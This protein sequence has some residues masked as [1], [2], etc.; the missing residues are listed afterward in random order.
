MASS[1]YQS[2][3]LPV[4]TERANWR[5]LLLVGALCV[6]LAFLVARFALHD[7]PAVGDQGSHRTGAL[8]TAK[9]HKPG[10]HGAHRRGSTSPAHTKLASG[11]HWSIRIPHSW[12]P[13]AAAGVRE[14]AG[15]RTPSKVA[16]AGGIVIVLHRKVDTPA[17]LLNYTYVESATLNTGVGGGSVRVLRTHV[18]ANHGEIEYLQ[19]DDNGQRIHNL[20]YVVQ[21]SNGFASLT[22]ATPTKT[23]KRDVKRV[24]SY[25]QTFKGR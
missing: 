6:A 24:E 17:D 12:R 10:D 15:W 23:F 11:P 1:D 9:H 18:Y 2:T 25:L 16:G 21:T 13:M 7:K 8:G 4:S 22:Y 19:R 3:D 14:D 20:A 5:M